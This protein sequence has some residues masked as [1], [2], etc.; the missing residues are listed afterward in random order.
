MVNG[1]PRA[2]NVRFVILRWRINPIDS[3]D[4]PNFRVSVLHQP[5]AT[6]SLE[7]KPT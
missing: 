6:V 5:I 3:L 1:K 7:N 4:V 2:Q